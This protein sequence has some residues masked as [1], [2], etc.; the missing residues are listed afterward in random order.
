LSRQLP[1]AKYPKI[2]AAIYQ[3]AFVTP[4]ISPCSAISRKHM[5]QM[6]NFLINALDLPQR[7]QR[8]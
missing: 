2:S 8:L 3:L 6:P 7:L 4:G 1:P 5:R